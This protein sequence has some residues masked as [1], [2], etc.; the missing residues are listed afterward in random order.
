ML[1]A[2]PL[3]AGRLRLVHWIAIDI[4]VTLAVALAV[5]VSAPAQSL[6]YGLPPLVGHLLVGLAALLLPARRVWPVPVF[7][8]VLGLAAAA[9]AI[10]ASRVAYL[11]V[12]VAIYA[13]AVL[14]SR[15][16]ALGAL[17]T[18]AAVIVWTV[19]V[20][21][22]VGPPDTG[23]GL[24]VTSIVVVAAVWAIGVAVREQRRYAAELRTVAARRAVADERLRI[25]RELH[26]VVAHG[27]SVIAVQAG[28]ANYV[29][30]SRPE[31]ARRALR[32]IEETSR[33]GLL[34]LRQILAVLRSDEDS[35]DLGPAPGLDELPTLLARTGT[36][37]IPVTLEVR[38]L[39]RPLPPGID[40]SA[41]R[42]VQEAL[43]NVVKHAGPAHGRVVLDYRPDALVIDVTDDGLGGP[44]LAAGGKCGAGHGIVGMRERAGLY[45]GEL[46]AGPRPDVGYAVHA[47]LPLAES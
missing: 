26:D 21:P 43:T 22:G 28:V 16:F 8:V 29:V 3:P 44:S 20:S 9:M 6:G 47:L 14:P 23:L 39:R 32:S 41:Y 1:E 27:M 7:F 15:R 5:G 34:E 12:A 42:I 10:G 2:A 18:S 36:A 24:T 17:L 13:V 45:G 46:T 31:E 25:A 38:G 11:P 4:V 19:A 33:A 35:P 40:L 30:D 37:G